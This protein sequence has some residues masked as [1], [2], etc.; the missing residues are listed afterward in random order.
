MSVEDEQHGDE[1]DDCRKAHVNYSQESELVVHVSVPV[2][3][4]GVDAKGD[5]GPLSCTAV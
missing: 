5:S 4:A 2:V 1:A 3:V